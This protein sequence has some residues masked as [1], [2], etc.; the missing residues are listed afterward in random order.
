MTGGHFI[1]VNKFYDKWYNAEGK[2][3]PI[4]SALHNKRVIDISG[5][6]N[7]NGTKVQLWTDNGTNAQKFYV[8]RTGDDNWCNI[9]KA[10]TFKCLD[11]T[12]GTEGKG[13][14]IQLWGYNG[15]K[16]QQWKLE[17]ARDGYVYL[18]SRVGEGSG[19][20]YYLDVSGGNTADGTQIQTWTLNKT[21]AQ[22]WK[23][24]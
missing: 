8:L 22:K 14:K 21:K 1:T 18:K 20:D 5:N 3:S 12:S 15:T 7:K 24:T 10:G 2:G 19:V 9:F 16:A 11:V 17:N 13:V 6:S 23:I 4:R